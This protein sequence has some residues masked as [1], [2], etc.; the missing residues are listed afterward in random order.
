[1]VNVNSNAVFQRSFQSL[2]KPIVMYLLEIMPAIQGFRVF[3]ALSPHRGKRDLYL[4]WCL[5]VES[6][7]VVPELGKNKRIASL[8]IKA[9]L[10]GD[11][12]EGLNLYNLCKT[13][14]MMLSGKTWSPLPID[15]WFLDS[16][17]LAVTGTYGYRYFAGLN[18]SGGSVTD[19]GS[20]LWV[21]KTGREILRKK[22][23]TPNTLPSDIIALTKWWFHAALAEAGEL[24]HSEVKIDTDYSKPRRDVFPI[25]SPHG[26]MKEL[27]TR[28]SDMSEWGRMTKNVS[29]TLQAL[30]ASNDTASVSSIDSVAS[31]VF[32][33]KH[34]VVH[35][36]K[37]GV[38]RKASGDSMCSHL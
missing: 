34:S 1:V 12:V 15:D 28:K 35:V 10:A 16:D 27:E 6:D 20:F 5:S 21:L 38:K 11:W 9:T 31:P 7:G 22:N 32:Q 37:L 18:R 29:H 3:T 8:Q 25:D 30:M 26:C 4:G 36:E 13:W 33:L 17:L 23:S 19:K 2:S 14:E 24:F